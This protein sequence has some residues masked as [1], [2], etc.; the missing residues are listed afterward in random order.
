MNTI[1]LHALIDM[2]IDIDEAIDLPNR[3][4]DETKE[5]K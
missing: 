2:G 3:A 1:L 4:R 5:D